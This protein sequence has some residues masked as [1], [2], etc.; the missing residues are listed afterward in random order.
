M[1]EK[2]IAARIAEL[3]SRSKSNAHRLDKLEATTEAIGKL[4]TSMEVMAV[5]QEQIGDTVDKLDSKVEL[6]ESK[7]GKKYEALVEKI[8]WA[9]VGA[10]VAW[11]L[12]HI[13]L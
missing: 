12:S 1:D 3:D 2:D 11:I 4:A 10:V 9:V 5:R 13:G 7:P 8:I 6:L